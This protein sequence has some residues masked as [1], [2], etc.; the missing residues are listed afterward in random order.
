M[1]RDLERVMIKSVKNKH[2]KQIFTINKMKEDKEL[3]KY[4]IKTRPLAPRVKHEIFRNTE[5]GGRL[6]FYTKFHNTRTIQSLF[7]TDAQGSSF[8]MILSLWKLKQLN[9]GYH[10]TMK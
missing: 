9:I 8:S 2:I 10:F 7:V 5:A 6:S 4:L 3:F 1:K